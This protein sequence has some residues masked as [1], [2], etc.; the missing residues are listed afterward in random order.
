MER[1]CPTLYPVIEPIE[2]FLKCVTFGPVVCL[3]I[4]RKMGGTG[5][6]NFSEIYQIY[7]Q[8]VFRFLLSLSGDRQQAEDLAQEVFYR[9]LL[10]IQQ[11][12]ENESMFTWLCTIGK[13]AWLNECRKQTRLVPLEDNLQDFAPDLETS[14]EEQEQKALLRKAILEL[15]TDYQDVVILHIYGE[16][17]LREIAIRKGKSES[18]GKVTFYRAKR[19]LT[20]K[21]EGLR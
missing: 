14:L 2:Y 20:Q 19:I 17:S 12:R 18:W 6:N 4:E 16:V 7:Y 10:H 3:T 1:N 11:Y 9:A 5:V 13:N 21:L 15:P 8:R